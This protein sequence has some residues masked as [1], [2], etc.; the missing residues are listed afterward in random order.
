[1]NPQAILI[2]QWFSL[3]LAIFAIILMVYIVKIGR[4]D[5][6]LMLL[7][8]LLLLNLTAFIFERVMLKT[9]GVELPALTG[10][11][12]SWA[13]LIQFQVALTTVVAVGFV[14]LFD[15]KNGK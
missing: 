1:M 8:M 11:V 5:W 15:K 13:V 4:E 12:N 9:W 14:L 7:P 6:K 2:V 10:S 3:I